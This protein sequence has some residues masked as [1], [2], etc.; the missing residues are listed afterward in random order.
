MTMA[1]YHHGNV[2]GSA[3]AKSYP[4]YD[5]FVAVLDVLGMKNWL[6][7]CSAGEIASR[8]SFAFVACDQSS[9]G[10]VGS[11]TYGPLISTTHFSDSIF[12]W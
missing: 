9:I 12:L 7:V 11:V 6:K 1:T 10:S 5:R 4:A 2:V 3:V 8:L